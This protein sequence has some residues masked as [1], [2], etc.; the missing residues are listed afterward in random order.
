[1]QCFL[2][3]AERIK[4]RNT[5]T[6]RVYISIHSA[7]GHIQEKLQ[8]KSLPVAVVIVLAWQRFRFKHTQSPANCT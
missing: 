8:E 2:I 5:K 7:M 1:M 4:E 3:Q 6:D